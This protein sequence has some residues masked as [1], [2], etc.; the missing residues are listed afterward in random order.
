M[1]PIRI[2]MLI[3]HLEK[4]GKERRMVELVKEMSRREDL[5]RIDI[6]LFR[7]DIHYE[8]IYDF[9][10]VS[11]KVLVR[12]IKKDP[13][14]FI[15]LFSWC[16]KN[17]PDIIHSWGSMPT[18]YAIPAAKLLNIKL[19]NGMVTNAICPKGSIQ[20]WRKKITYPFSDVFLSNSKA[21]LDAYK[22]SSKKGRVIYN[23]FAFNRIK[24]IQDAESVRKEF[25]IKTP[26]A[27]GMV[28]TFTKTKDYATFLK[29]ARMIL[30]RRDDITFLTVGDGPFFE[31]HKKGIESKYADKILLL[32][33]LDDVESVINVMDIAVLT[34]NNEI[35]R[36]GISNSILE[37]MA[38]GIPVVATRGGGTDEIVVDKVT[39]LIIDAG[40]S[41]QLVD[42][43]EFLIHHPEDRIKMGNAGKER[44]KKE[45]SI[46]KM[47]DTTFEL[48]IEL[49]SRN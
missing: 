49:L 42:A 1:K 39:G 15:H 37:Y 20:W 23:G 32:G 7:D 10:K 44:I 35:H 9:P 19:I 14:L 27:V 48:Y 8:E 40:S 38:L 2:L 24:D 36:E 21:G 29:S 3:D 5:E 13:R 22:I 46:Q 17:R 16:R 45:F 26:V 11:V 18:I 41:N 47:V 6:F 43:L 30:E 33:E 31:N 28:A 4:G 34:T 12:K 25:H